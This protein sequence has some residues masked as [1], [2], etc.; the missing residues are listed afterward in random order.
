[1]GSRTN[2][3]M[4]VCGTALGVK[5]YPSCGSLGYIIGV[6]DK[7]SWVQGTALGVTDQP[8]CR[9]P[10]NSYG[11]QGE[12]FLWE[13]TGL[14]WESWTSLPVGIHVTVTGVK[15]HPSCGAERDC[16]GSQG[17]SLLQGVEGTELGQGPFFLWEFRGLHW[18]HGP[19]LLWKSM[20]HLRKSRASLPAE[21]MGLQWESRTSPPV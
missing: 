17:P 19:A 6:K 20:R 21:S 1:M 12:D 16:T 18:S 5:N 15:D 14:H 7:S 8:P 2:L 4:R 10:C 9:N 13:L 11:S 3:P